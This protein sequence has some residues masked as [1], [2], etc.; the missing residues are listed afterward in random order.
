MILLQN[1]NTGSKTIKNYLAGALVACW[2]STL[3]MGRRME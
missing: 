1:G 2:K 3:R